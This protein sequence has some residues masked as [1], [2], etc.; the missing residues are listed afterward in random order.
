[1]RRGLRDAVLEARYAQA[2]VDRS[3]VEALTT[4]S[5]PRRRVTDSGETRRASTGLNMM[6]PFVFM[7]L[8]IM[9]VMVGAVPAHDHDR[10][11]IQPCG[12]GAAGAAV[13]P[14][15]LMTGKILG[16]MGVGVVMLSIYTGVGLATLTAF[17]LLDLISPEKL[18]YLGVY[19][20]LAYF[21]FAS[22]MAAIGSA[23]KRA[24]E[25]S[26]CRRR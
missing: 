11:E 17:S 8:L 10:G 7:I 13:S 3:D 25:R 14:M 5:A 24:R 2:G 1:M 16:Q 22:F 12:R 19:F 6:L 9:S 4:V 15:Q 18:V 23:V 20:V 21:I 26:R